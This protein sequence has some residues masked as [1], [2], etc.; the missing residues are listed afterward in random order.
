MYP[1]CPE[2]QAFTL[3]HARR[4]RRHH[5]GRR[6]RL[7]AALAARAPRRAQASNCPAS[8]A[9][10][11]ADAPVHRLQVASK[12]GPFLWCCRFDVGD[13]ERV[14][15]IQFRLLAESH[16]GLLRCLQR[17][18]HR[19]LCCLH[20]IHIPSF[21]RSLTPRP[22]KSV[23]RPAAPASPLSAGRRILRLRGGAGPC[24]RLPP[25][26]SLHARLGGGFGVDGFEGIR[27]GVALDTGGM[28]CS[29]HFDERGNGCFGIWTVILECTS[30][31][32]SRRPKGVI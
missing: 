20:T 9:Q 13:L 12:V 21:R 28:V 18:C 7:R 3:A 23:E 31:N 14:V 8:Y 10:H 27:E 22:D 1:P 29:H 32:C 26:P 4:A 2:A 16:V 24:G 5:A 6:S 19:A 17:C 25:T 11:L 15:F 30:Y